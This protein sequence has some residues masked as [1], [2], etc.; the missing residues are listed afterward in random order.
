MITSQMSYE[1]LANEVAKDYMDVSMIMRKKMPDALKYFRRQSRFP[2]FLFSTVTSPRKNKW[3]LIFFAKSK[4]RLKQYVDSFLVCVRETDHG[5]YVY[6]YDLPTKEGSVTGVTFYPP[7][8]FSRYA[9]RMGLELTGEDLIK[10]YFKTNT[11]MRYN[12]DHLF[13]SEEEMKELLN[14][15]WYTSPD[16]ISLGSV[17]MV[18]GMELFICKTFVPWNMCKKDQLITCGK[19]EMFRLQE[20]LE[21]D[22]HEEDVV[23]RSE[24]NKI[25][26]EFARMILELIDKAG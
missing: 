3:I 18:S 22:T 10:R 17:M 7:H 25:V 14:P 8:F 26:Q 9:L 19:E 11:A 12:T 1:E 24:N 21:L 20:D 13:L 2:M 16:G 4:R 23:S 5:K 6:R 15:V